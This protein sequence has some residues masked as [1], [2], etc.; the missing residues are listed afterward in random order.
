MGFHKGHGVGVAQT[1]ELAVGVPGLG[2]R[3]KFGT[4]SGDKK[5]D[6][7]VGPGPDEV[8]DVARGEADKGQKDGQGDQLG[9][10]AFHA[11]EKGIKAERA[12]RAIRLGGELEEGLAIKRLV[13]EV[14]FAF[15]PKGGLLGA[16][17]TG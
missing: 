13:E 14:P 17:P 5:D 2:K 15:Q 16:L 7:A 6:D 9:S 12:P 11:H 4:S 1:G 3:K 8:T 10:P